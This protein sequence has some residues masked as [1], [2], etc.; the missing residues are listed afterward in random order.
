[1]GGGGSGYFG[2]NVSPD[3]QYNAYIK[4]EYGSWA[5]YYAR[6]SESLRYP[7]PIS[8]LATN[9]TEV[10]GETAPVRE[11][12]PATNNKLNNAR[13]TNADLRNTPGTATGGENLATTSDQWLRGTDGNAGR[14]PGQIAEQL[15]GQTFNN[16]GEFREAF[17]KAVANDPDLAGQFSDANRRLMTQGQAPFATAMQQTGNGIAQLKYNLHHLQSLADGG[18]LYDLGNIIIVTPR[19]HDVFTYGQ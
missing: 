16:F 15:R 2:G 1:G 8:S 19:Y 3:W 9:V 12:V 18:G 5:E 6:W 11:E 4:S 7:T 14:I 10:G 17:W 13:V